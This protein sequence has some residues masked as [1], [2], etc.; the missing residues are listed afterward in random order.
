VRTGRGARKKLAASAFRPLSAGH[1]VAGLLITGERQAETIA[2]RRCVVIAISLDFTATLPA[3]SC[4]VRVEVQ[5]TKKRAKQMV[6]EVGVIEPPRRDA[7]VDVEVIE[8]P[9]R[10]VVVDVE[11]IEPPRKN[12]VVDVEVI[13]PPRRNMVVDVEVMKKPPAA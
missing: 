1:F 7:V 4:S 9:R 12:M 2:P 11:V 13:E 10:D 5:V 3:L 8:P 6:V